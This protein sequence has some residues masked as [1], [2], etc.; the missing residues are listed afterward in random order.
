MRVVLT[1]GLGF[2]L[3]SLVRAQDEERRAMT[4][5]IENAMKHIQEFKKSRSLDSLVQATQALE[6]ASAVT[7]DSASRTEDRQ[8]IGSVWISIMGEIA[9]NLD[10]N[11]D[12]QDVPAVNVLPP[13]MGR[14]AYPS[15]VDPNSIPDL[16][17]RSQY[18]KELADNQSKAERYLFQDRVRK[19]S[20]RAEFGLE[21]FVGR[22]YSSADRSE[23][24]RFL[25]EAQLNAGL[26]EALLKKVV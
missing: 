19:L 2:T 13:R 11:F 23:L 20:S 7:P 22:F 1:V 10:A 12:P 8:R 9:Q 5:Q 18:Q 14:V 26:K 21:T 15:G 6:A 25:T 24:E 3:V 17:T 4:Q 16:A